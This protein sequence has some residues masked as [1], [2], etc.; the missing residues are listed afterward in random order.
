MRLMMQHHRQGLIPPIWDGGLLNLSEKSNA[1]S[2]KQENPS[3]GPMF[4]NRSDS[5]P[6][7]PDACVTRDGWFWLSRLAKAENPF[8]HFLAWKFISIQSKD[9]II[10]GSCPGIGALCLQRT[11]P[12][13]LEPASVK[14]VSDFFY[15]ESVWSVMDNQ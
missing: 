14:T 8:F 2:V 15:S 3:C 4:C 12:W 5:I 13:C 11:G 7:R 10:R 9:P 6:D 1:L